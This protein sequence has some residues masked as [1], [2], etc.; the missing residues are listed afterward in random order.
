MRRTCDIIFL[1]DRVEGQ[2]PFIL[3]K[4][5]QTWQGSGAVFVFSLPPLPSPRGGSALQGGNV[6]LLGGVCAMGRLLGFGVARFAGFEQSPPFL[7]VGGET[8]PRFAPPLAPALSK[9]HRNAIF[10]Q[11]L[12]CISPQ[13]II[14]NLNSFV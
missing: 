8:C 1:R 11:Y 10:S 4:P 6:F 14:Q 12:L 13:T 2:T 9:C 7:M 5:L 3:Q